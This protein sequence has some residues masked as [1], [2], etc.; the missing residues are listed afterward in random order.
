M[1]YFLTN[2]IAFFKDI[3]VPYPVE[4]DDDPIT[5]SDPITPLNTCNNPLN[6]CNNPLNTCNLTL[7]VEKHITTTK[8]YMCKYDKKFES[9]DDTILNWKET[10]EI[11]NLYDDEVKKFNKSIT[12][13][14]ND[15]E[16]SLNESLS[17]YENLV[18][19]EKVAFI[20]K[21]QDIKVSID[22]KK[23]EIFSLKEQIN[24]YKKIY[25]DFL[26]NNDLKK[27]LT[28]SVL[29]NRI[30]ESSRIC[31]YVPNNGNVIFYYNSKDDIFC[32]Y[33]NY[34]ISSHTL[35]V[36]CKSFCIKNSM[37]E[38]FATEKL[39]NSKGDILYKPINKYIKVGRLPD[40]NW[41]IKA[42]V[43]KINLKS[44]MSWKEYK[45]DIKEIRSVI[46]KLN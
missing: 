33:S 2:I 32:Y 41:L 19:A 3:K 40:F 4:E 42:P 13:K 38:L 18:N 44:S 46:G 14:I 23:K 21:K 27:Q 28:R 9:M 31:E 36:V 34:D 15:F 43:T 17:S 6:T 37:K 5:P 7:N 39:Q 11:N 45:S 1:N 30:N 10:E 35:N 22:V 20:T 24:K 29:K 8:E 12:D 16:K 25:E 26:A